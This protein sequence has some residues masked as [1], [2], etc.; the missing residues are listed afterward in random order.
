MQFT[1]N[2]TFQLVTICHQL[3]MPPALQIPE[4]EALE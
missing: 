4:A 3:K 2:T 1:I